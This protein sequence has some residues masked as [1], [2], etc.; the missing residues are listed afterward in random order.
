MPAVFRLDL[1]ADACAQGK[2]GA[3]CGRAAIATT[4]DNAAMLPAERIYN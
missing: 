1:G 4:I 2:L 3:G